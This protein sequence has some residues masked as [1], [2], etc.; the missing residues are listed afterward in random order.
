MELLAVEAVLEDNVE[1]EDNED[2]EE[3]VEEDEVVVAL[4]ATTA[5]DGPS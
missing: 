2:D 4:P 5:E 1:V 3:E